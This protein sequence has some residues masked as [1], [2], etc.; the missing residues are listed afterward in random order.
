MLKIENTLCDL[1][2]SFGALEDWQ[3]G[4]RVMT[5]FVL[6]CCTVAG[7]PKTQKKRQ[8]L[9]FKINL[10]SLIQCNSCAILSMA[11]NW[12]AFQTL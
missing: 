7:I 1:I 6:L 12:N 4:L 11:L 10:K 2:C 5:L 3:L 8:D 9:W